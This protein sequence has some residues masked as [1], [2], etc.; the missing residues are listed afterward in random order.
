MNLHATFPDLPDKPRNMHSR[1]HCETRQ[2]C[3][4]HTSNASLASAAFDFGAHVVPVTNSTSQR[5]P[6]TLGSSQS[7][8]HHPQTPAQ[9]EKA[10]ARLNNRAAKNRKTTDFF[11]E[12]SPKQTMI[13]PVSTSKRHNMSQRH[14]C[15]LFDFRHER[16]SFTTFGNTART[17]HSTIVRPVQ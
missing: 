5:P 1:A 15:I 8:S 10:Q 9:H 3:C 6:R 17:R 11:N 2:Q 7:S 12:I 4:L 13:C 16:F 14:C